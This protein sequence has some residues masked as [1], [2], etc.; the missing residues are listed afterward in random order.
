MKKKV[1]KLFIF[2]FLLLWAFL[3]LIP[4]YLLLE[5]SF[6]AQDEL[7][8][9]LK[10]MLFE[11][12][13][14]V[15]FT[16]FP[17]FPTL[18]GYV[19]L[20]LDTPE[21][22]HMFWNSIKLVIC[23]L[24]GQLFVAVPAA[25]AF[26]KFKFRGKDAIFILYVIL[27]LMPFQVTMLS[28]YLT[29]NE[30]NL[31]NTHYAIILPAIF[32]T[33]P[34]FLFYRFFSEIPDALLEATEIDGAGRIYIFIKIGCPLGMPGIMAAMV[35]GFLE[36]W[37]LVEQPMIFLK[38]KSLWP[39]SLYLPQISLKEA[40]IAFAASV[41]VLLPSFLVFL[42]GQDSLEQGIAASALKE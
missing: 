40:A 33:F 19:E 1:K 11:N 26:S 22:F 14:F 9:Y 12:D 29:L 8:M 31:I 15:S 39:L 7:T 16:I 25:W 3:F 17:M 2:N 41:V 32:S 24:G 27:M 42:T 35:L 28:N 23:I 6:M 34:V 5:G 36:Y 30:L 18:R 13:K 20:L 37:N 38:E 21:F 10:P 4:I